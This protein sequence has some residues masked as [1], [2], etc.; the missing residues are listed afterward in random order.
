LNKAL[1]YSSIS[2]AK[3]ILPIAF[4]FMAHILIGQSKA[5]DSLQRIVALQKHDTT[6]LNAYV[7]LCFEFLRRDLDKTKVYAHE[8]MSLGRRLNAVTQLGHAYFYMVS[9]H[10]NSGQIDSAVY[11]LDLLGKHS[12]AHPSYWRMAANYNQAAGLLY[13]NT[14]QPK[15]ALPFMLKNLAY[16]TSS[17]ESRAGSLLNIGNVYSD[18]GNYKEASDYYMQCLRLFEKVG[19]KRGQSYALNSLG[20][21]S[22]YLGQLVNAKRYLERSLQIKE[23]IGDKRGVIGSSISLGDVYKEL[24]KFDKSEEFYLKG[25]NQAQ[26]V[27]LPLEEARAL[28]QLGLLY[29]K[30][31]ELDLARETM[32]KSL[33]IARST[34]DSL[35][36]T[37]IR[38]EILG[39]D[40]TVAQMLLANLQTIVAAGDKA[41]EATEYNRLSEYYSMNSQFDKALSYL[42]KYQSLNDSLKGNTVLIQF[43][44][45]EEKYNSDKK[46]RELAL[47]KKEHDLSL[48]EVKRQQANLVGIAIALV[49]VVIVSLA[50][51]NRYRVV[52]RTRRMIEL[53][54]MRNHIARDL[55]DDIGS[56]L[57]SINIISQLALKEQSNAGIH[58]KKI[59]THSA[60]MMENMSDIVWSINPANDS[61]EQMIAKMKEFAAEI[62]EPKE[63]EFTF[64]VDPSVTPLKLDVE[65]RKNMFLI[66]K[67]V[68]NNAAKYSEAA[69]LAVHVGREN[70]TLMLA[71]RDDGRGFEIGKVG[72]GNGLK[73]MADRARS[74]NAHLTQ[75]SEPGKGS[76][77]SLQ[78][79]I[80]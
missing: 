6:E 63:I 33:V 18:L 47:L 74:M 39:I 56:T 73:N 20:T 29:K 21:S 28:H 41:A 36:C 25:L 76:S 30:K 50:L 69:N 35:M 75:T 71:V 3:A 68:V 37:K 15:K 13:K 72:Q 5:I 64:D 45:L 78:V 59:A 48:A 11:Y 9:S 51:I 16:T 40:I 31:G 27:K 44:E 2:L 17:D 32:K 53:E 58:L 23:L 42:K 61:L 79:P 22:L 52:N 19:N 60:R 4:F 49:S 55:H 10:Q 66:F 65:K 24:G 67:E 38:S 14:G 57:S 54:R 62:L 1:N 80:T 77:L 12:A 26:Q 46:E 43:R 7:S 70:G 34:G 8:A